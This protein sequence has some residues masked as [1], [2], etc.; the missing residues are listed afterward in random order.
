MWKQQKFASTYVIVNVKSNSAERF[1]NMCRQRKIVFWD[2]KKTKEGFQAKITRKDFLRIKEIC[3]KTGTRVRIIKKKG[4]RFAMFCYRK[5][6]SFLV[7]IA[8]SFAILYGFSQYVWDISFVGNSEYTDSS[9]LKYLGQYQIKP[10]ILV[11]NVDCNMIETEL[12]S[13]YND[14]T[15][16]S[17]EISGTRLI[18]HIKENDGA[19]ALETPTDQ[20]TRD[21]VATQDGT[22]TSMVTRNGTPQ[23]RTGD[24]VTK[25]QVL[26]SGVVNHYDD[27]KNITGQDLTMAD[28]DV[29]IQAVIPYD[30]KLPITHEYKEYTG[31]KKEKHI[32][33]VMENQ[34]EFGISFGQFEHFDI[35][36]DTEVWKLTGNYYLP[37]KSGKKTYLEYKVKQGDYTEEEA[38]EIL[39]KHLN[40][41]LRRLV[42]NKVQILDNSV[43]METDSICYHYCGSLVLN[44]QAYEYAEVTYTP[45]EEKKEDNKE[46]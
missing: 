37:I 36:T 39:A 19:K 18:V 12:R 29:W 33:Q 17:A 30:E 10:G 26:V 27:G 28:A 21:I 3:R 46:E 1:L 41:Y 31:R 23:V 25:G 45:I 34:A 13:K 6:Y 40:T 9:L 7:G 4:I 14:I 16:V 15:W 20:A 38:E 43:K 32:I 2:I 42:Q 24:I 44:M 22:V 8:L 35:V 11:N 5:H